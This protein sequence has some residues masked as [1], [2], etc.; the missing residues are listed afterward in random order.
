MDRKLLAKHI[1]HNKKKTYNEN[2]KILA[3]DLLFKKE[4]KN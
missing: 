2:D 1:N 4:K 3:N